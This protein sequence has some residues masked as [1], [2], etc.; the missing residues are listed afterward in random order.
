MNR[1]TLYV[2]SAPS[3]C[4]KGTILAEVF[5]RNSNVF[6]SVSATTRNPREGEIDGVNYHFL[7]REKFLELVDNNGMLEY[8]E[9]CGNMYGTP[10]KAVEEKLSEGY[11]VILEIETK[12]A[13]QIKEKMPEAVMIFILPPSVNELRRRLNKR[14]T[15]T[16]EVI[17]KR[18]SEAEGEIRQAYDYDYVMMNGELSDAID[19]FMAIMRASKYD[20][21]KNN[22]IIDEVLENA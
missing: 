7:T 5:K 21:T 13:K 16:E 22:K 10:R 12:G 18:V 4:G 3:G 6:Y 15:E 14:G 1:G 20:K 9:F 19:D 11:D 2:V 8:A 17:E